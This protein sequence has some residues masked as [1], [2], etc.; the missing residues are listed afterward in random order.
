M[1]SALSQHVSQ[2]Q[3]TNDRLAAIQFAD[4]LLTDWLQSAEG[5][6]REAH[7]RA[8]NPNFWQWSTA[9]CDQ[10]PARDLGIELV[11]LEI[12]LPS[13]NLDQPGRRLPLVQLELATLD[14]DWPQP[15]QHPASKE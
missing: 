5:I 13:D 12:E 15:A 11:R 8:P 1:L 2:R 4:T 7:G 6:P 9:V 3:R 10:Q 14:R